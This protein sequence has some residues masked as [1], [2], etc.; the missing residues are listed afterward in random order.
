MD[1]LRDQIFPG[2]TLSLD[3]DGCIRFG[4]S[5]NHLKNL[6]HLGVITDDVGKRIFFSNFPSEVVDLLFHLLRFEGLPDD[7]KK[8]FQLIKNRLFEEIKGTFL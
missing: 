7:D 6:R 4:N 3:Q 2:P 5:T 1:R 8:P